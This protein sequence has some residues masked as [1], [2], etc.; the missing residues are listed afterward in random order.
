LALAIWPPRGLHLSTGR[1]MSS[2]R[3]HTGGPIIG[4]HPVGIHLAR[5]P[6]APISWAST[7]PGLHRL[8]SRGHPPYGHV[9]RRGVQRTR[10][11][12]FGIISR[13]SAE[14]M[15]KADAWSTEGLLQSDSTGSHS[16]G[17]HPSFVSRR[18][19]QRTCLVRSGIRTRRSA[20]TM[21]KADA[22]RWSTEGLLQSD[23]TAHRLPFLW[24]A[25]IFCFRGARSLWSALSHLGALFEA[26]PFV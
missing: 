18:G 16:S 8:P 21:L 10:L 12:R 20:E 24:W 5:P 1:S 4:S 3:R 7:S 9:S 15:L 6:Q 11:V 23:S 17:G 26:R 2:T 19:V 22:W 14:S 13:K 25:S